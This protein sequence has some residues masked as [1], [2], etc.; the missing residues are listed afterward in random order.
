MKASQRRRKKVSPQEKKQQPRIVFT[1]SVKNILSI[2]FLV[3]LFLIF[4]A[5]LLTGTK[6]LWE[7]YIEQAYPNVRF[8]TGCLQRGTLPLWTPYIFGGMPFASD[9]QSTLFYPP[10]WL[11]LFI[12]LL[13]EPGGL[14]FTWY[15][16]LHILVLGLGSFYLLRNMALRRSASVFA[17]TTIM[18]AGFVSMHIF[19][20][21]IYVVAWFPFA[22]HFLR[23]ALDE[24]RFRHAAIGGLLLGIST[25]GGYPQYSMHLIYFCGAWLIFTLF[26]NG[27]PAT[28]TILRNGLGY[29]I[30]VGIGLALAAV[31][32][33]PSFENMAQSMRE[34]MT[35]E[36]S[37]KGALNIA[38][39]STLFSPSFFG[40][41][42]LTQPHLVPFWG[43]GKMGWYFW[44]TCIFVGITPLFLAL[45]ALIDGKKS[46]ISLFLGIIALLS[47]LLALGDTTPLYSFFF[48]YVPGF[49]KFRIP[50]RF[51]FL[52]TICIMVLAGMGMHRLFSDSSRDR[53]RYFKIASVFAG[54][55]LI[56]CI[57]Y[58]L[59]AFSADSE[60]LHIEE[61]KRGADNAVFGTI[62]TTL[63]I[64]GSIA[65][66]AF[67]PVKGWMGFIAAA[68]TFF[69]LYAFG[70]NFAISDTNPKHFYTFDLSGIREQMS[71]GRFRVQGR[72]YRGDGAGEL[73]FPRNLGNVVRIPFIDGYNQLRLSRWNDLIW[74]VEPEKGQRLFNVRYIKEPGELNLL[75]VPA[76]PRFF[77]TTNI[78]IVNSRKAAINEINDRFFTVGRDIVL[79]RKPSIPIEKGSPC[80]GDVRVIKE[81][82]NRIELEVIASTNCMLSVSEL[83]YPAWKA[84]VDGIKTEVI[85]ANCTFRGIPIT[86][87]TH[88]IIMY[89]QSDAMRT[90]ALISLAAL[91]L[92]LTILL[93]N[94]IPHLKRLGER[95]TGKKAFM[96]ESS[97]A[98]KAT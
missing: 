34:T 12:S 55:I 87:G 92:A 36:E 74:E 47:I 91:L 50:G 58:F 37:V 52:F 95:V 29:I 14:A 26:R 17:A 8:V 42:A 4:Y 20:T 97:A 86:A 9:P 83:W 3:I 96:T 31:Q 77:L 82:E 49:G 60:F 5:P 41:I 13:T 1:E 16:L 35:F 62:L 85:P 19:H 69:E 18:F 84:K 46:P 11:Y 64:W 22:F 73:L 89:Y 33:L 45:R 21:F 30:F 63:F 67:K 32:Y 65:Y 7:D 25:L 51:A 53:R 75:P 57:L 24:G 76:A 61:I 27:R 70:H 10:F 79:E 72:I 44:E 90:G 78:I 71:A 39:L 68:F 40:T 15:I 93:G 48:H 6:F 81:N 98:T 23:K 2:C 88:R 94:R 59:G 80:N 56:G 43:S 38:R 54:L 28:Q 66:I